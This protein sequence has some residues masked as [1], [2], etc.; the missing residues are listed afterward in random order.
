[1]LP[2]HRAAVAAAFG[3]PILNVFGSSEGLFG[4]SGPNETTLTFASDMCIVELVDEHDRPVPA[5]TPSAKVL[6]TN[7]YNRVQPLIRYEL[8]DSFVREP[9]APEHGHLRATVTG[10][11]AE[12][13]HYPTID[14]H[15]LA[16]ETVVDGVPSRQGELSGRGVGGVTPSGRSY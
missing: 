11:A 5:G 13:L 7:L 2:E 10:R 16:V 8:T 6:V 4:A 3:V 15:P 14:I 12:L 1:M 9:D